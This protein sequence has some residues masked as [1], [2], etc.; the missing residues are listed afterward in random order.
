VQLKEQREAARRCQ[1]QL[2]EVRKAIERLT[3]RSWVKFEKQLKNVQEARAEMQ[4]EN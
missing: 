3:R 4:E 2:T 1:N